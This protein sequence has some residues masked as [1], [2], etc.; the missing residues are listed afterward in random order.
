MKLK[1]TAAL[2]ACFMLLA[3][4]SACGKDKEDPDQ[5][6]S[7]IPVL[8]T[9]AEGEEKPVDPSTSGAAETEEPAQTTEPA[10]TE[11]TTEATTAATT[12]ATTAATTAAT[13]TATTTAAPAEKFTACNDTIYVIA[14]AL[15][16]RT[17]P[18]ITADNVY[19]QVKSGDALQRTGYNDNWF[20]IVIE[21][22]EYYISA[23]PEYTSADDPNAEI[24]FSV[25]YETVY[26]TAESLYIRETPHSAGAIYSTLTKGEEL[27]RI[28]Y[29][30]TWSKVMYDGK[31]LYCG[32]KYLSTENP[33]VEATSAVG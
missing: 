23:N 8:T 26:V 21:D 24:E 11:A 19:T 13:T 17:S 9:T 22:K 33:I 3:S 30:E 28:G 29:H 15:N 2:L 25:R 4:L 10:A 27:L 16:V 6:K 7:N 18:A 20:R 5:S 1:I 32:S 14:S 12:S 31:M